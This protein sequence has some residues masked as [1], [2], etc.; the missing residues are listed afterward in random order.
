MA[1]RPVT[2][3]YCGHEFRPP[4]ASSHQKPGISR[5]CANCA[6]LVE[7]VGPP[8]HYKPRFPMPLMV[9]SMYRCDADGSTV[10]PTQGCQ[11]EFKPSRAA[12]ER[13]ERCG[14]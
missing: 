5:I 7:L 11:G 13:F 2:C 4:A 8:L 14:C 3:P 12:I 10:S 6:H 9:E 1:R